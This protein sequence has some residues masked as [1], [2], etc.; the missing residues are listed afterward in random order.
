MFKIIVHRWSPSK[1][2]VTIPQLR[3]FI[4][5]TQ[6]NWGIW[7]VLSQVSV[8]KHQQV[9]VKSW[10]YAGF[11]MCL[12][13]MF[14]KCERECRQTAICKQALTSLTSKSKS[15]EVLS[16][17]IK[18]SAGRLSDM[19]ACVTKQ[20]QDCEQL[21]KMRAS[22]CNC[23]KQE[24]VRGRGGCHMWA[25]KCGR[26][27]PQAPSGPCCLSHRCYF[28]QLREAYD[29]EVHTG[30]PP[31]RKVILPHSRES[32]GVLF[33]TWDKPKVQRSASPTMPII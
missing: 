22:V 8:C 1:S 26:A 11:I 7:G 12:K 17:A 33:R 23:L 9:R 31:V 21:P 28:A 5:G 24:Q 6:L 18:L 14:A 30:L 4:F 15:K 16:W 2:V 10:G 13:Q 29:Y 32:Q 27:P 3:E 20:E 19:W 25:R